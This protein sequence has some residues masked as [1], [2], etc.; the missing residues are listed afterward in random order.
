MDAFPGAGLADVRRLAKGSVIGFTG[1]ERARDTLLLAAHIDNV[2]PPGTDLT[3]RIDG[4]T[5]FGPGTGDNAANV[6]AIITLAEILK[7]ERVHL[8]RNVAF[9]G[10][11]C[12]EGSGNLA[13]I[14]EALDYLDKMMWVTAYRQTPENLE[15]YTSRG[16][17][18]V[19][20]PHSKSDVTE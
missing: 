3:T 8:E 12:E 19:Y 18:L 1:A 7:R 10:T 5:L 4:S 20:E 16:D 9:C 6:A 11:V 13:G 2:F 15:L 17:T 14:G